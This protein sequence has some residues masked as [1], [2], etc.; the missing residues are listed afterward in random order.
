MSTVQTID[1][2]EGKELV[3]ESSDYNEDTGKPMANLSH[4]VAQANLAAEFHHGGKNKY[5]VGSELTVE[6]ADGKVLTPDI[7]VL[8]K[9][10]IDWRREPVRY[11]E[12]PLL[13]VEILSPRQG[14]LDI[15]VKL[16]IYFA[17]GVQ[18]VWVVQPASQ[19]IDIYR[20]GEQRPQ[21]IQQGEAKDPATGLTVRLEEV[22]A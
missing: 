19:S 13:V 12:V 10:P 5:L 18:S 2:P 16:D 3:I 14:Y 6:F 1:S 11:Q 22:F 15:M 8:P 17:N 4:S 9:R 21:I 7:A 20:P